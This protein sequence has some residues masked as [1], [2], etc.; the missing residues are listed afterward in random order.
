MG[1]VAGLVNIFLWVILF[2]K[3]AQWWHCYHD[4][5]SF[6]NEVNSKWQSGTRMQI[7]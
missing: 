7:S 4:P 2:V 5:P 6:A 3:D 1:R